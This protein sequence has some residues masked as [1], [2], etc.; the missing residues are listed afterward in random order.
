MEDA[1]QYLTQLYPLIIMIASIII[2]VI[3][4]NSEGLY[5]FLGLFA[6]MWF[7]NLMKYFSKQIADIYSDPNIPGDVVGILGRFDRPENA[8]NCNVIPD[9]LPAKSYG[10][11]SGHSEAS[12][13][14]ST[15]LIMYLMDNYPKNPIYYIGIG[16]LLI[17]P[18]IV[19][20]GRVYISKCHTNQQVFV[21][22]LVGIVTGIIYYKLV[23]KL[24][25]K[26]IKIV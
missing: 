23:Q 13:F 4:Q 5:L 3:T 15:Y 14:A 10:M 8:T 11:P 24:K 17:I 7:N 2:S 1:I 9:N 12:W 16:I 20:Y 22:A 6:S 26:N 19:M 25:Y 18:M 21:G